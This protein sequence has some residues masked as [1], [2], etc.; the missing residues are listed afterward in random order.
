MSVPMQRY[1]IFDVASPL[2]DLVFYEV[3]DYNIKTNRDMEYGTP[4]HNGHAYP[5]HK[6]VYI[7]P[8][9][10]EGKTYRFYYAAARENQDEYNYTTGYESIGGILLK[11]VVRTYVSLREAHVPFNPIIGSSMPLVPAD[12]F[13]SGFVLHK[14]AQVK[15]TDELDS[16]FVFEQYT[17]IK[18]ATAEGKEYGKVVTVN[19]STQALVTSGA[20][21]VTGINVIESTVTPLGN[22]Q[23]VVNTQSVSGGWPSIVEHVLGKSSEGL[24]PAKFRKFVTVETKTSKLG[25]MPDNIN[26]TGNETSRLVKKETPD[27]YD[28]SITL[29][30]IDEEVSPLTGEE[31]GNIVTFTTS[32]ILVVDGTSADS[33][34]NIVSSVVSPLGNGKSI[35]ET[36]SVKGGTWPDPINVEFG[37]EPNSPPAKYR[38]YVSRKK[39]TRKVGSIPDEITLGVNE[40]GK[41]YTKETPDRAEETVITENIELSIAGIDEQIDQK[42]FVT[43]KTTVTPSETSS[44]P[45]AGNGS[46]QLIYRSGEFKIYEN[47]V[48]T[49]IPRE[50]DAGSEKD[51]RP[52]VSI[53]KN[54][55]YSASNSINTLNGSSSVVFDDGIVTVY[56][57]EEI[58]SQGKSSLKGI[59]TKAQSWGS[60]IDTISYTPSSSPA[61]GGST[62]IAYSDGET[63]VYESS[64][65]SVNPYGETRD[66]DPQAWGYV[67]LEGSYSGSISG[68]KSRQVWS[69]GVESVYLNETISLQISQ[70]TFT[71]SKEENKLL[72]E[73]EDISY[74]ETPM[75]SGD[76]YR[77]NLIYNVANKRVYQNVNINILPKGERKYGSVI[78]YAVPSVLMA[79]EAMVFPRK[80]GQL[81]VYYQAIIEEGFSGSYPCEVTERYEEDPIPP[82]IEELNPFKP[83]PVSFASPYGNFECGPTLH[84]DL[85]FNLTTGTNDPIYEY[86]GVTVK[87]PPTSPT[88]FR[89]ETVL[90]SYTSQPYKN[91]FIVREYRINLP[92]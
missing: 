72:I 35:K 46:S 54:K 62:S 43:I 84:Q 75:S 92:P 49:A 26:L 81:R 31:Y 16:I 87:I 42:P 68:D 11:T 8:N 73:T 79:I 67:E 23:S 3:V 32:E 45:V 40:V 56:E 20:D 10:K 78:Q 33:G 21:P 83:M 39:F 47:S 80:D 2:R 6:L 77:S 27:R 13:V 57:V 51:E 18:P 52:Y 4:H 63:T 76:N 60:I 41:T 44:L 90:A 24:I 34:L 30:Q 9:D 69:N 64:V 1:P 5:N 65:P 29:E 59:E 61:P 22:G 48:E 91:G 38:D 58:S 12:K 50:R 37:K 7:T 89:G 19:T 17:Y 86:I 15:A 71:G 55:R 14:V 74:S 82:N 25:E 36:K 66:K 53:T 70:G 88:H 85:S 28:Q